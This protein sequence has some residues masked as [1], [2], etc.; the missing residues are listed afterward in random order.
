MMQLIAKAQNG[1]AADWY[2]VLRFHYLHLEIRVLMLMKKMK[3]FPLAILV[4][5]EQRKKIDKM[6]ELTTEKTEKKGS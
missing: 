6:K 5:K 2:E 1:H 4:M 3:K